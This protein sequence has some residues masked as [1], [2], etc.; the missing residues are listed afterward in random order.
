MQLQSYNDM[1]VEILDK[2]PISAEIF[3][4]ACDVTQKKADDI[5]GKKASTEL[6]HF[7]YT[8]GHSS[9]LEHSSIT[10]LCSGISRSLLAQV[11]RHRHFSFTSASQHY[12][13]YR[14]Y[15]MSI[16]PTGTPATDRKYTEALEVAL[17][18]YIELIELGERPEEARQ[19]LPNACCVN[20]IITANPRALVNFFEQRLCLRNTLEMVIFARL[21]Y[22][23]CLNWIPG[24]FG[25]VTEPCVFGKCN[26][27]ALSCNR[28]STK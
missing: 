12:Q 23:R 16:R 28:S 3:Q 14:D 15:P 20:L 25:R 11:T 24:L 4:F 8:A 10:V 18:Y 27:G 22:L 26:Q 5:S 21:L 2:T 19:V 7:L 13:D 9:I 1:K 6:L 17:A